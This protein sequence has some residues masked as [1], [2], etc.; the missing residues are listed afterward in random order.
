MGTAP[1]RKGL[2]D[3]LNGRAAPFPGGDLFR[4]VSWRP[5]DHSKPGTNCYAMHQWQDA[6]GGW[7]TRSPLD[8]HPTEW[9]PYTPQDD[10]A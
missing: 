2:V 4:D 3:W 1:T 8:C 7:V 6:A 5:I 9:F 10:G